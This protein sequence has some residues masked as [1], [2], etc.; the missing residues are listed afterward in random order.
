MNAQPQPI[1]RSDLEDKMRELQVEVSDTREAATRT[2]VTVGAVVAVAVVAVAFYFGRRSG[3][4][5]MTMVEVRR[6]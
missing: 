2:L 5:R 6:I 3:K 4:R 1:R